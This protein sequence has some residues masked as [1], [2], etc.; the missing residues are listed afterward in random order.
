MAGGG[1]AEVV[2]SKA[3]GF[4]KGD[5]VFA[6]TGWQEYAALPAK[7]ADQAAARSSR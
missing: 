6:D 5:L 1:V 2:E 7:H 4:A 3:P